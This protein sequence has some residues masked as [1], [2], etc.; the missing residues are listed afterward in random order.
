MLDMRLMFGAMSIPYALVCG[1]LPFDDDNI[2]N[3]IKMIKGLCG[4]EMV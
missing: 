3:L 2:P 4:N 1:T